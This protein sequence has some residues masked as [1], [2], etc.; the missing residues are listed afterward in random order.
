MFHRLIEVVGYAWNMRAIAFAVL[1]L[2]IIPI[3]SM[4]KRG[5]SLPYRRGL[6]FAAFKDAE[7][8]LFAIGMFLGYLGFYIPFFY[9]QLYSLEKSDITGEL[10]FCLL[11]MMNAAGFFGRLVSKFPQ[12]PSSIMDIPHIMTDSWPSGR[13]NWTLQCF[14]TVCGCL[15]GACIWVD[16]DVQRS[17]YPDLLCLVRILQLWTHY[18]TGN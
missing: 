12:I 15:R 13:R 14:H 9:I 10:N 5:M 2:S 16:R 7:Y 4:T 1:F 11:P 8:T 3:I 17:G 18:Y 6:S